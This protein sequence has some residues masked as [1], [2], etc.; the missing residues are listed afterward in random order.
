MANLTSNCWP[1]RVIR[2]EDE[3]SKRTG[4]KHFALIR[5][6]EWIWMKRSNLF[7][8]MDP[9]GWWLGPWT[10]DQCQWE[11]VGLLFQVKQLF[12]KIQLLLS[13]NSCLCK[14]QKSDLFEI[15][16]RYLTLEEQYKF[17]KSLAKQYEHVQLKVEIAEIEK[18]QWWQKHCTFQLLGGG[19]H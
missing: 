10:M 6:A 13:V 1:G 3:S 9:Q 15:L 8:C 5:T 2:G 16:P 12:G 14:T 17:L 11:T 4:A 19:R 18:H 7:I